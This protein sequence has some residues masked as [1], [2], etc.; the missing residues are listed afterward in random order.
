MSC[1]LLFSIF[2]ILPGIV[3]M[4]GENKDHSGSKKNK[5]QMYIYEAG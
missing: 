5:N 2:L 1:L 4:N 3:S